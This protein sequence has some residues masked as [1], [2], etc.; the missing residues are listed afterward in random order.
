MTDADTEALGAF[1]DAELSELAEGAPGSEREAIDAEL[2]TR[3]AV[4]TIEG[5]S[6]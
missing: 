6:S 2:R 1:T 5:L 3:W 4:A